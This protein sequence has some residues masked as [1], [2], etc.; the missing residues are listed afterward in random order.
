MSSLRADAIKQPKPTPIRSYSFYEPLHQ[1]AS[2]LSSVYC[3]DPKQKNGFEI[4]ETGKEV[5]DS[6][7]YEC[8]D[9]YSLAGSGGN[10]VSTC[11][12][13][14]EWTTFTEICYGKSWNMDKID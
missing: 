4:T 10:I 3:G 5:N 11:Q 8:G 9:G 1:C 12:S 14:G 6:A 7:T 2:L 13:S